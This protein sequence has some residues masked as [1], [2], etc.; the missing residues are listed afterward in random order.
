M[1]PPPPTPTSGQT[2]GKYGNRS[3]AGQSTSRCCW[4]GRMRRVPK[5][6][7]PPLR[8]PGRDAVGFSGDS[9]Y[10]RAKHDPD[11][12]RRKSKLEPRKSW[13][14]IG[15]N[16]QVSERGGYASRPAPEQGQ[17]EAKEGPAAQRPQGQRWRAQAGSP[18]G[19]GQNMPCT[20]AQGSDSLPVTGR[21]ASLDPKRRLIPLLASE[22]S[23]TP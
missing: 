8:W 4:A 18:R 19:Q 12:T 3:P 5:V 20:E 22:T 1:Q 17:H 21:P 16:G 15:R 9:G 14:W 13:P 11:D 2:H 7:R 23:G 6:V 10:S